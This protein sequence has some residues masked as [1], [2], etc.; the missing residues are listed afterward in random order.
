MFNV[1]V[2]FFF[3]QKQVNYLQQQQQQ[4]RENQKMKQ[5]FV[6]PTKKKEST[7]GY[8][9]VW[10]KFHT[11]KETEEISWFLF[12]QQQILPRKRRGLDLTL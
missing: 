4:Q 3:C 12:V 1:E 8:S 11:R 5:L 6:F 10:I 9:S 7:T 2:M